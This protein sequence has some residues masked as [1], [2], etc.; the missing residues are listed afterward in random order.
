VSIR[1]HLPQIAALLCTLAVFAA[2]GVYLTL[3]YR[4]AEE[5]KRYGW[6]AKAAPLAS[7][8]AGAG[9]E[10][11]AKKPRAPMELNDVLKAAAKGDWPRVDTLLFVMDDADAARGKEAEALNRRAHAL[12]REGNADEAHAQVTRSLKLAPMRGATWA[13]AA[14]ILAERDNAIASQAALGVAIHLSRDRNKTLAFLKN[15]AA[16]GPKFR[17]VIDGVLPGFEKIPA[18]TNTPTPT[19]PEKS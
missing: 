16:A 10:A 15:P 4:N 13:V 9:V 8:S 6:E 18:A 17:A 19:R 14:E 2:F 5:G 1:P 3:D 7:A 12:L 11:P